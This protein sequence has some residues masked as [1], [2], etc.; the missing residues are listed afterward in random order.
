QCKAAFDRY[1]AH[2][3]PSNLAIWRYNNK[4][5]GMPRGRQLRVET[6]Q[7]AVV[8]W[9]LDEW[10][11]SQDTKTRDTDLGLH[12]VD[13]PTQNLASGADVIFTFYWPET[14]RWEGADFNVCV[15]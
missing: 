9:S 8:H 2:S 5:R 11:S 7:P 6:L 15:E 4:V 12:V 10:R 1:V 14:N 3:T 13:L